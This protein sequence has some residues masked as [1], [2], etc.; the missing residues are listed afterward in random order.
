M[1][2]EVC[3]RRREQL[4]LGSDTHPNTSLHETAILDIVDKHADESNQFSPALSFKSTDN[5]S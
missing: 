4:Q 1:P 3:I 2:T 5:R